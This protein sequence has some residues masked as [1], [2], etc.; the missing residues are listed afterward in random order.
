MSGLFFKII[1]AQGIK[2]LL[3]SSLKEVNVG[4]LVTTFFFQRLIPK[5]KP[6]L[7]VTLGCETP[8]LKC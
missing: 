4:N 8:G 3:L 5:L 7:Q 2:L 6:N 1:Y